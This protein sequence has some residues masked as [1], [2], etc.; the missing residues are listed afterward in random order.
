MHSLCGAQDHS[1]CSSGRRKCRIATD[2][3]SCG[4]IASISFMDDNPLSHVCRS[5]TPDSF[6]ALNVRPA[7]DSWWYE[8]CGPWT[9]SVERRD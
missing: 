5:G 6:D 7:E 1:I 4:R 9:I 8:E 2:L 3:L